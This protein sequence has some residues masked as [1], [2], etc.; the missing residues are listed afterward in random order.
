MS[1]LSR[2]VEFVFNRRVVQNVE[3]EGLNL[4]PFIIWE[5]VRFNRQGGLVLVEENLYQHRG[6]LL[7]VENELEVAG[8]RDVVL[9]VPDVCN[10]VVVRFIDSGTVYV[11]NGAQRH[12]VRVVAEA[13]G[14]TGALASVCFDLC[15]GLVCSLNDVLDKISYTTYGI[16]GSLTMLS[17]PFDII[18]QD[19]VN[20][21]LDVLQQP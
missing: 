20:L 7:S 14:C 5:V 11:K 13:E 6:I 3:V 2:L 4:L 10:V 16:A 15:N 21:N 19:L 8:L 17:S 12:Q 18:D 1:F 9:H